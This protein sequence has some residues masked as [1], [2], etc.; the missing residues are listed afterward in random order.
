MLLQLLKLFINFY[1][2]SLLFWKRAIKRVCCSIAVNCSW[3][4]P[5]RVTDSVRH[6]AVAS[7]TNNCGHLTVQLWILWILETDAWSTLTA[8]CIDKNSFWTEICTGV[9]DTGQFATGL[10]NKAVPS[11]R[12]RFRQWMKAGGGHYKCS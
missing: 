2:Q 10:I 8:S 9:P 1:L 5:G 3:L 11:F 6:T 7:S 4:L 12:N